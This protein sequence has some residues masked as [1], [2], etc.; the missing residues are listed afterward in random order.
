MGSEKYNP[1]LVE[2]WGKI[3]NAEKNMHD[4]L[5]KKFPVDSTVFVQLRYGQ[6]YLS[7][8]TVVGCDGDGEV[9]VR[10][11]SA[12]EYSRRGVRSIF[13]TDVYVAREVHQD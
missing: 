2:A 12:K 1:N 8:G 13:F 6:K 4:E 11:L 7:E 5:L 3:R 9:R 10:L